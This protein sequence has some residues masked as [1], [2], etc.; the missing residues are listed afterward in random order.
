VAI[1][2]LGL[3]LNGFDKK[4]I[5]SLVEIKFESKGTNYNVVDFIDFAAIIV[6]IRCFRD[7]EIDNFSALIIP[8]FITF[9]CMLILLFT[10]HGKVV[11][12][13]KKINKFLI[14]LYLITFIFLYSYGA[15]YS[16]NCT[17][18]YS[19]PIIFNTEIVDKYTSIHKR[20]ISYYI[21]VAPWGHHLD[22]ESISISSSEY[23]NM[24]I[25]DTVEIDMKEGLLGIPWFYVRK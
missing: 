25:G 7:N 4:S 20:R 5:E 3:L 10:T 6:A 2:I 15:T 12:Q 19:T 22:R 21:K 9:I 24:N 13:N 11:S 8:G 16:I 14:H 17:Y 18:D 1:P 23:D